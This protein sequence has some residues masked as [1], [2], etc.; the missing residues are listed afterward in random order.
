MEN[1]LKY[2]KSLYL[3]QHADNPVSWFPWGKDAFNEAKSQN[4]P[5]F[6]SIGYS[7]C[8][9]CHVMAHESFENNEIA[10]IINKL[11]IPI[12]V[13]REE[14]PDIDS[15]YMLAIQVMTGQGGWP[16]TA[17]LTPTGKPFFG[18]TYFP[19]DDRPGH[20]GIKK[21]LKS[22]SSAYHHNINEITKYTEKLTETI[23]KMQKETHY[24]ETIQDDILTEA[25]QAFA[26]SFD[27][28]YGGIGYQPKFP[29]P[30]LYEF[31]LR[32]HLR[33]NN[34]Q[35]YNMTDITLSKMK[36]GGIY[37]QIG[38]GFHRYSTDMSWTVP[39]FEKMLYDNALLVKLYTHAYQIKPN[40]SF[41]KTVTQTL[42]YVIR[43]MM[44][45][46][47]GFYSSQ[48][49]DSDGIEGKFFAWNLHEINSILDPELSEIA[50]TYFSITQQG[51]FEG[52]NILTQR[53]PID[54]VATKIGITVDECERKL[55]QIEKILFEK[56]KMR[57]HPLCD[58][59]IIASWNGLMLSAFAEAGIVFKRPEYIQIA[60]KNAD[61]LL[62]N[63]IVNNDIYRIFNEP[64]NH[65]SIEGY[66][67][68]YAFIISAFFTLHEVTLETKWLKLAIDLGD[69][70]ISLF[71][72]S[73]KKY[74]KDTN[75]NHEILFASPQTTD[76]NVLPSSDSVATEILIK[77]ALLLDNNNLR[78]MA[79]ESVDSKYLQLI[80]SPLS[81]V[82]WL[83]TIDSFLSMPTEI[84]I[85]GDKENSK[86]LLDSAYYSY[87]P[88][89]LIIGLRND[90]ELPFESPLF[91]NKTQHH[92]LP[93]AFVC[94][95]YVCDTPT[96]DPI[97]LQS[98]IFK[99]SND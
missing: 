31:L 92:N 29:Q 95:N 3:L 80:E 26:N 50:K 13:D 77:M 54:Q 97:Q 10:E 1:K 38:G 70:M 24:K 58:T 6:L 62:S 9:W 17:F 83:S 8:H 47:G 28:K 16:L 49:A 73:E 46:S 56:R 12:K 59:K 99:E 19:P 21:I 20:V 98:T 2:E 76:G 37:D 53:V 64:S 55:T 68:D 89:R 86:K 39:H 30:P 22:V 51:N 7:A 35:A 79:K 67:E 42:D 61:F 52:F 4:K 63:M 85:I 65:L 78:K 72:D 94:H 75:Y 84:L 36:E 23:Q 82:S 32:Y 81:N 11:F 33:E 96:N 93:T 74:F 25:M 18:G 44:S 41:K 90:K 48:D 57:V 71:W 87:L 88:N 14:R 91:I 69:Q 34:Q 45:E 60:K 40:K 66:L 27:P 5:I 43:E 15:V